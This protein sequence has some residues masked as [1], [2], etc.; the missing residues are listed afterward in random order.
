MVWEV[1]TLVPLG[2]REQSQQPCLLRADSNAL[3]RPP[4]HHLGEDTQA[5]ALC[6]AGIGLPQDGCTQSLTSSWA[7]WPGGTASMVPS[8]P[9]AHKPLHNPALAA[10]LPRPRRVKV[11]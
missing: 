9:T 5:L 4:D 8:A 2:C 3:S 6:T 11:Q 7:A 10:Q 1:C